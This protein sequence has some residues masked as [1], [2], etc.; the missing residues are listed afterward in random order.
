MSY[1]IIGFWLIMLQSMHWALKK[2]KE[3]MLMDSGTSFPK[4]EKSRG[5]LEAEGISVDETLRRFRN[6]EL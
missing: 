1:C 4:L 5:I 3:P 6:Y 2:K